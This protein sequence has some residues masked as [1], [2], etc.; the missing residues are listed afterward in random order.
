MTPAIVVLGATGVIGSGVVHAALAAGRTVIAVARDAARL[1]ALHARDAGDRSSGDRHDASEP[2][3]GRGATRRGGDLHRLRGS[4]ADDADAAALAA[5]LR[6]LRRPIAGIVACLC[7]PVARG[8]ILDQPVAAL[9]RELDED[10]APH[11]AAARHLLPLLAESDRGSSYVLIGGPG[12]EHPWAGYGHRSVCGAALRMLARVLHDEARAWSVRVQ[13]LAV[14]S[15]VRTECNRDHAATCWPSALDVGRRALA[16]LD[17]ADASS[18][19][20][21]HAG[22]APAT[23]NAARTT[24]ATTPPVPQRDPS[25]LPARCQHDA[26]KLLR[27]LIAPPSPSTPSPSSHPNQE[28]PSP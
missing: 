21:R 1:E 25:L 15:P 16:L 14:D 11:F 7:G 19:I 18:A 5:A 26:G 4:V 10:L 6:E 23:G 8:R 12:G 13:M 20:V 17:R 27:S 2:D 28:S 24:R 3:I 22:A 9:R